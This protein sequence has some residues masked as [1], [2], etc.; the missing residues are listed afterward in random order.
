MTTNRAGRRVSL[1]EFA[2]R[3]GALVAE[4]EAGAPVVITRRGVPVAMLTPVEPE[5]DAS[6]AGGASL[7]SESRASYAAASVGSAAPSHATALARLVGTPAMRSV[8]AIFVR[9][10]D[11]ALHQREIAR[12]ARLGLRSAQIALSRL[13]SLGLL[14]A[15]R[16]GNRLYYRAVRTERFEQL[17]ALLS[18]EIGVAGVIER[19]LRAAAVPLKRALIFGSIAEGTD[20]VSSDIDLL[21]V[22]D[23]SADDLVAPIAAA[24]REL[25]REIDLVHYRVEEF[26]RRRAEGN[27]FV[28]AT[29]AR[30]RIDV[31]EDADDA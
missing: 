6:A 16:D 10:P 24:Q 9:D 8:V 13:A 21:V 28:S 17:R 20:T 27:H 7:A 26:E 14:S 19:H 1:S 30:P 2:A 12:R 3:P 11:A 23:A 25:G 15:E 22:S 29:L 31:I 18:R 5:P 4:A